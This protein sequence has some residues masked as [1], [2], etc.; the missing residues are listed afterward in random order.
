VRRRLPIVTVFEAPGSP[1]QFIETI[2]ESGAFD[3]LR[4]LPEDRRRAELYRAQSAREK[5]SAATGSTEEFLASLGLVATIGRVGA[6]T[7]PRVAQLLGKTNQFNLTTRRHSA[8]ELEQMIAAGAVA[9]WLRLADCFGD[10]GLVGV[11]V[12]LERGGEWFVDT[13]LLSCRV[14]G[15][16]VETA[17]LA[18]LAACVAQRGGTKLIGEYLATPRNGLVAEFYPRHGFAPCGNGLWRL[19][20]S[21]RT[22]TPPPHVEIHFHE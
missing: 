11:A 12:A 2:E 21:G 18:Q 3:Q 9:L 22:M 4:F 16:Q 10:H 5:A 1:L 6:E 14:I 8:A 7:L 20:F 15:R 19:D 13:F 17:L